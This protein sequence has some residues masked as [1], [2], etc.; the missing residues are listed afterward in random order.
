MQGQAGASRGATLT[1][2]DTDQ[3]TRVVDGT[4]TDSRG[5]ERCDG[6]GDGDKGDAWVWHTAGAC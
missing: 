3:V 5:H 4:M 2:A 6:D 1:L